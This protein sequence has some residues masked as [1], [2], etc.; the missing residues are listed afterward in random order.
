[1]GLL[2]LGYGIWQYTSKQPIDKVQKLTVETPEEPAK[3]NLPG[4]PDTLTDLADLK[5]EELLEDKLPAV[6][7]LDTLPLPRIDYSRLQA[8]PALTR[9][10]RIFA[11]PS[12]EWLIKCGL[13]LLLAGLLSLI[14]WILRRRRKLI[15]RR[16]HDRRPPFRWDFRP[17]TKNDLVLGQEL[18]LLVRDLKQRT[19]TEQYLLDLPQTIRETARKGGPITFQYRRR[20]RPPEYLILIDQR[21]ARNHQAQLFNLLYEAFR[22]EEVHAVRFYFDGDPRVCWNEDYP[23]KIGLAEL[24]GRYP[25]HRLLIFGSGYTFMSTRRGRLLRWARHFLQWEERALLTPQPTGAWGRRETQL[26][27][28]FVLLPAGLEGLQRLVTQLEAHSREDTAGWEELGLKAVPPIQFQG[29]LRESLETHFEPNLLRWIA[30]CALWPALH[31]DL[32]L[33]LGDYQGQEEAEPLL[34]LDTLT[35]LNRLPWFAEGEIPEAAR[36][37]LIEYLPEEDRNRIRH[38]IDQVMQQAPPPEGSG[39]WDEH[40]M[41]VVANQLLR[42]DLSRAERRALEQELARLLEDDVEHDFTVVDYLN[43]P[44][45][46]VDY[47]L[48]DSFRKYLYHKGKPFYGWRNIVWAVPLWIGLSAAISFYS[49]DLPACEEDSLVMQEEVQRWQIYCQQDSAQYLSL[50]LQ[51]D[52]LEILYQ[53]EISNPSRPGAGVTAASLRSLID[54]YRMLFQTARAQ[55][56]DSCE[57]FQ[58][59]QT[60][61]YASLGDSLCLSGDTAHY[62]WYQLQL[63]LGIQG[64]YPRFVDT[65]YQHLQDRVLDRSLVAQAANLT[66]KSY[67][68]EALNAYL[69]SDTLDCQGALA[70]SFRYDTLTEALTLQGFCDPPDPIDEGTDPPP[71]PDF[72]LAIT[73]SDSTRGNTD[74]KGIYLTL[75]GGQDSVRIRLDSLGGSTNSQAVKELF[76]KGHTNRWTLQA[77]SIIGRLDSLRIGM[78]GR[79]GIDD[80]HID[81]V[82][83][84]D[85]VG[86]EVYGFPVQRWLGDDDPDGRPSWIMLRK[87][88][89]PS[90]RRTF[91][92]TGYLGW[93]LEPRIGIPG[94]TVRAG[95]ATVQS[96]ENGRFALQ[97]RASQLPDSLTLFRTGF[98]PLTWPLAA[99][100]EDTL[101]LNLDTLTLRFAATPTEMVLVEGDTFQM[102]AL[103]QDTAAFYWEKPRHLVRL[104][105]FYMD[106]YEVTVAQYMTYVQETQKRWPEWLEAGSS[107]HIFTGSGDDSKYYQ[108]MGMALTH[109]DHPIVGVSWNDAQAYAAWLSSKTTLTYELPTEAQWEFAA[110]SAGK[111]YLYAWGNGP[112]QGKAGGNIADEATKQVFSNWAIWEGYNDGYIYTAPV[113]I[114]SPNELY[115]YDLTGNVLGMVPG[116]VWQ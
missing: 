80:W 84:G 64:A 108:K 89:T 100:A 35:Q 7:Q 65:A 68:N 37:E 13:I 70:R 5:P 38:E 50:S 86:G 4:I 51:I 82:S 107:Y 98:A 77:P 109:P 44:R 3:Q 34:S 53:Q 52:S 93:E 48:P 49:P 115:I 60:E 106:Q 95:T 56:A 6:L 72:F 39:A 27:K 104:S 66:A 101:R 33:F 11:N 78:D 36:R 32:T 22:L 57:V 97:F 10:Q 1:M 67:Y 23:H 96:A 111:N 40:R 15:A 47:V 17:E 31:W 102:G 76:E 45:S 73:T 69:R 79:G 8:A 29:S 90:A 94:A 110:R 74:Q 63:D 75:F 99:T 105:D 92:I 103:P 62:T 18:S 112:P 21:N 54:N 71:A 16:E 2:A 58:A 88:D 55:T 41:H 61:A 114:Y 20:T 42:S 26:S 87:G 43:R 85:R 9:W 24:H 83:L 113:G 59:L 12:S 28:Y 30:A 14:L 91:L 81:S 46:V 19:E 25:E 116:P